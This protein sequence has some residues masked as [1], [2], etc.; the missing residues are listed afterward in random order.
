MTKGAETSAGPSAFLADGGA[1]P[2]GPFVPASPFAVRWAAE[3]CRRL[4]AALVATP[5]ADVATQ[6]GMSPAAL[7]R[8]LSGDRWV[9]LSE[10]GALEDVL[11][12][13]LLPRW[14]RGGRREG[15]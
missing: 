8:L 13:E 11:E 9:R 14:P 10:V 4:A 15:E 12:C 2:S 6:A 5:T 7:E 1:W 3:F